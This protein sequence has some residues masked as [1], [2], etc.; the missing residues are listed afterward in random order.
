MLE[1]FEPE[2]GI[3]KPSAEP[4]GGDSPSQLG[5]GAQHPLSGFAAQTT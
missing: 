2:P 1:L 4:N 3:V 5:F